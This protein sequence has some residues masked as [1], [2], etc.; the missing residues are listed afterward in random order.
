M[1]KKGEMTSKQIISIILLVVGFGIILV[2][3]LAYPWGETINRET[4]H[5]SVIIRATSPQLTQSYVPLKCKEA[6]FC[7]TSKLIGKGDCDE[8]KNEEGV[9][10]VRVSSKEDIEKFLAREYIDC[11]TMMGEGKISLFSQYF[12]DNYGFGLVYP[13]CVICSRIAFDE[14]SLNANVKDWKNIDVANYMATRKAPG[15][16]VSYND[17]LGGKKSVIEPD[18]LQDLLKS[19]GEELVDKSAESTE[20]TKIA[21]ATK[22]SGEALQQADAKTGL[23]PQNKAT[24]EETGAQLSILYM[25]IS[26]PGQ[27]ES[28]KNI[29]QTLGV[30]AAGSFV[31]APKTSYD[32]GKYL[33]SAVKA[34][35][36]IAGIVAVVGISAQQGM[37]AWS[38]GITAGYCGDISVGTEARNGCSVVRMVNHKPEDISN[39][40]E[41]I[42][43]IP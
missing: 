18:K 1:N 40:C 3:L 9:T 21:K 17:F 22:E 43:S 30:S 7:I 28:L 26:A 31:V 36:V 20:D 13:T 5:E 4:C 34:H 12:A 33:L 15:Q 8:F 25:Q 2:F 11:W 23:T 16:E 19:T 37:V 24:E 38:R 41:V 35:P 27:F 14:T 39:F 10:K 32:M 29:G 42:E 6:K